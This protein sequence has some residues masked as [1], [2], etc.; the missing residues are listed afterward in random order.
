[1]ETIIWLNLHDDQEISTR[2]GYRDDSR[3]DHRGEPS[4]DLT[5]VCCQQVYDIAWEAEKEMFKKWKEW[6]K[7]DRNPHYWEFHAFYD[8]KKIEPP[9]L[10]H[11][12]FFYIV[13]VAKEKIHLFYMKHLNRFAEE[14]ELRA[15]FRQCHIDPNFH[16]DYSLQY[17]TEEYN[18]KNYQDRGRKDA[19]DFVEKVEIGK[20]VWCGN[21]VFTYDELETLDG[22]GDIEMSFG[23][24]SGR[25]MDSG[26]GYIHDH[27]S[28]ILDQRAFTVRLNWNDK[29]RNIPVLEAE[30]VK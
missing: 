22:A 2:L 30:E 27:C 12:D 10:E 9:F 28:T 11:P 21:P 18:K 8:G 6:G 25:D 14:Y 24:G 23:Y 29:R 26:K 13:D 7:T 1:M 4:P 20:C 19:I 16:Y 3:F 17:W 15:A 5:N